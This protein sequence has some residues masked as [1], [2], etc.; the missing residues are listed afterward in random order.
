MLLVR[1]CGVASI[2][3][4]EREW[5]LVWRSLSQL[6]SAR[7]MVFHEGRAV[8]YWMPPGIES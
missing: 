2:T 3:D 7:W 1:L 5:K 4:C 6:I 8:T